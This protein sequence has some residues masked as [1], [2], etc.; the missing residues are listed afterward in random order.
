M[1]LFF[2][3]IFTLGLVG[4]AAPE[5]RVTV[6]LPP[7]LAGDAGGRLLLF[8]EPATPG[9]ANADEVD[10]DATDRNGV[11]V[12]GRDVAGFGSGRAVTIDTQDTAFPKGFATLAP[13]DYRV[14]AVLDRN[15]DYNYGGRGPGDLVSKVA[16]IHFPL[17]SVPSIPLDHAAPP[18]TDQFDTTGIPP[19]AAQQIAA[20]RAHLHEERIVSSALTRFRG[21]SQ[22]VAAW[23]LTPP[24][25]DPKSR[26]TYPTVYTANGFGT[27]HKLDGQLLSQTWH[28][29][30]TGVIP[31]MIWVALDFSSPTG[32]T[33]FADSLNNGPWGQALVTEVIPALEAKYRM[34]AKPSGRFLTGHSSGGWFALWAIV[35]YPAMFGG[36][37]PTSPDPVDFRNFLGVDLY[38]P[39]ANMYHDANGAP[40]PLERDH[41]KILTMVETSA[42]VETVLGHDG[43]QLRSFEWVFSPRRADGTPAFMFDRE[44]GAVDP[45][46]ANYWRDNYDI[47]HRIE[48]DWPRLKRDLDGKVHLTVGTADSYYL[49]GAA[50]ELEAVFRK[51][52]GRADFTFVPNA[53]HGVADLY[54]RGGDRRAL[55][56]DITNAMYAVARPQ[57]AKTHK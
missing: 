54:S 47:G 48:T 30:E 13:G 43:G 12:A 6:S 23:I 21:T 1:R 41:D 50:H 57:K 45:T 49:D 26:T 56:K 28:M 36:S 44:S 17:T 37:W 20:S 3:P 40:R 52:G 14:Q 53:T 46:V 9:N 39:G 38:A 19:A 24:G 32:T 31:P 42:K 27:N 29:M 5:T 25:Y 16:T 34:D 15:G 2:V 11:S 8:A 4:A 10:T 55:W 33:E 22:S 51:V 18:E 7:D 35:R